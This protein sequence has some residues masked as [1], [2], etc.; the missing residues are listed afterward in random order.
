MRAIMKGLTDVEFE[1]LYGTEDQCLAAL[2]AA[3]Q[4][5]GMPCP[6]CV[7]LKELCLRPPRRLHA[8]RPTLVGHRGHRDGGS[9]AKFGTS[10][11]SP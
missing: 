4:R 5:E 6:R 10:R 3:R 8:L 7:N 2:V 9:V 11:A 1:R